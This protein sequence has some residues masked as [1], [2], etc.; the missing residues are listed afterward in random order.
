ML[1][2]L[3]VCTLLAAITSVDATTTNQPVTLGE[4]GD[5]EE[6]MVGQPSRRRSRSCPDEHLLLHTLPPR[7]R[8]PGTWTT[9]PNTAIYRVIPIEAKERTGASLTYA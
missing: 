3:I 7:T 6:R 4:S 1:S 9:L 5:D 8:V 2:R